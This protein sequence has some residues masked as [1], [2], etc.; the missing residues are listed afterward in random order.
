MGKLNTEQVE[1][2]H[3]YGLM[4][5]DATILDILNYSGPQYFLEIVS[6]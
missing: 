3:K 1:V 4:P 5:I 2:L 6:T